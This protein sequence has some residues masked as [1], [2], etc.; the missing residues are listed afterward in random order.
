MKI[1]EI[2]EKN[3]EELKKILIEKQGL[4]RKLRFDLATK[5]VKNTK[6][7][8]TVKRDVAKILTK[9]AEK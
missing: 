9:L 7:L 6:E 8:R 5:Q 3:N 1:S 4:T 2:R